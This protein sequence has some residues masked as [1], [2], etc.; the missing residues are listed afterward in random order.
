MTADPADNPDFDDVEASGP[1]DPVRADDP[2]AGPGDQATLA[3]PP[4][5]RAAAAQS[6]VLGPD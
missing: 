6:T 3:D 1:D 5:D 2:S 4:D